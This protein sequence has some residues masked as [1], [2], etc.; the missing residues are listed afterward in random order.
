VL[1]HFAE[2]AVGGLRRYRATVNNDDG[3]V[4]IW[5]L[6]QDNPSNGSQP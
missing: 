5:E 6:A 2:K 3:A 1:N 4:L